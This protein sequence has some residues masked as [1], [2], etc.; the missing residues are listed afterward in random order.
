MANESADKLRDLLQAK[1]RESIFFLARELLGFRDVN[2]RTHKSTIMAL[3]SKKPKKL[4]CMPRGSLKSS[5]ACVAYPIWR[6]INN[7]N[8]RIL[9]DSELYTNSKNF[10]RGIKQ[11]L[12][13]PLLSSV[14]GDFKGGVWNESEIVI[15]QRNKIHL[16]A[17]ITIGGIG[18]SKVGQHF[19]CIIGDDYCSP[20]NTNT[21]ENAQKVVDHYRYNTSILEPGGTYVIIGTRYAETDI[22]AHILANE[23]GLAS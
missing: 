14:F 20:T 15:A 18:C 17:S 9:I 7:P 11:H 3:E 1:A 22:I 23:I 6:L 12:E 16:E 8:D 2:E 19:N 5:L 21:P 10:L 13:G 4:I